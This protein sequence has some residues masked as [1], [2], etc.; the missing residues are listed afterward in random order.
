VFYVYVYVYACA[1]VSY[2]KLEQGSQSRVVP[3]VIID[4]ERHDKNVHAGK[5][6]EYTKASKSNCTV[7]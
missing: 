1:G 5:V 7:S 2:Q 4:H 6:P 3:A